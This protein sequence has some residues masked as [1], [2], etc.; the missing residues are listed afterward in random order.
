M[1]SRIVEHLVIGGG[2]AGSMVA[3]RLA[4]SGQ[5]VTLIER[6][7]ADH[8]KVCGEFLSQEAVEYLHRAG[9][10]PT[11][12]GAAPIHC[13]RLS[14]GQ[15]SAEAKLPF[16]ALSLSRRVLDAALLQH[17][18]DLGCEVIRGVAV[19]RLSID[20]LSIDRL[21]AEGSRWTARCSDGQTIN[22]Q[23]V[24][25]ASG[26]HDLHG[27]SRGNGVQSDMVGFKLH[28]RLAARQTQE[29]R[30][31]MELFLFRGG[32][33]GLALVEGEVANLCLVVQRQELRR[34]GTWQKL[35][36]AAA[37]EN[38]RLRHLLQGAEGLWPR[39]LAISPIPY[40]YLAV[41]PCGLWRVGDQAAVIPSFTGDGMSIAMH[42]AHLAVQ[43][44]LAGENTHT[45]YRALHAQLQGSVALATRISQTMVSTIGRN[46]SVPAVSLIPSAMR[47]IALSTR[48][49]A[50]ALRFDEAV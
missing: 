14:A 33:G 46:L 4:E 22:A 7:R 38:R 24:F 23:T 16:Q 43:M 6:E 15:R 36:A 19:D 11:E 45:Y 25:L 37:H 47:W 17:A 5:S 44:Y 8:H 3:I 1:S 49:P 34:A 26:K 41:R 12:L 31:W 39:P 48:I 42:S 35:L 9:V 28:L 18:A 32:Y 40:G 50:E 30:E 27:W 13:V 20:R 2:P 21:T 29:L 10:S